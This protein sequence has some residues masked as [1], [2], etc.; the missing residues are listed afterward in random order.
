MVALWKA[1]EE[2]LDQWHDDAE[3]DVTGKDMSISLALVARIANLEN[4][5]DELPES[6]E[7]DNPAMKVEEHT[8]ATFGDCTMSADEAKMP[9][10]LTKRQQRS[11]L[12]TTED[13][14][15]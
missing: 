15:K 8:D 6:A 4:A 5:V 14:T 10:P 1:A 9:R 12:S 13:G 7:P 11:P 3:R 2:L